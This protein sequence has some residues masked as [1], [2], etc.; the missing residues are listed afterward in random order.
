MTIKRVQ[1][2]IDWTP[3]DRARH[4]AIRETFKDQPTIEQ[5]VERGE[6]SGE[7]MSLDAYLQ[8]RRS[9]AR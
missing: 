4:R 9:G 6:L 5:L 7:P 3:E 2:R 1:K 8:H